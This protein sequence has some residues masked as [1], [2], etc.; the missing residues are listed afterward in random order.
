MF[1]KNIFVKQ[2][3]SETLFMT[4]DAVDRQE[5]LEEL[6]QYNWFMGGRGDPRPGKDSRWEH[7][8]I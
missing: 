3:V 2:L 1:L 8:K 5:S 7:S 4:L 6:T